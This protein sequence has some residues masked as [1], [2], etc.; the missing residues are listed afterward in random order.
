MSESEKEKTVAIIRALAKN[1][2][3]AYCDGDAPVVRCM[4]PIVEDDLAIWVTT[5]TSSGKVKR[6]RKNPQVCLLTGDPPGGE[7]EVSVR[8]K[9]EIVED[10]ATRKR[11]WGL[12]WFNLLDHF[13][14]GPESPD[15]CVLRILPE[16]IRWRESWAGGN[17][18]YRPGDRHVAA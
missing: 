12:A 9:A 8:G 15:F 3:M 14:D 4:S 5:N 7:R 6:I 2:V 10:L 18:V 13:P 17:T 1:G 11:V 16:E